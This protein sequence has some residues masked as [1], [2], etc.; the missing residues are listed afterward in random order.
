MNRFRNIFR[1]VA[2]VLRNHR[3]QRAPATG[4]T[5]DWLPP[6][7]GPGDWSTGLVADGSAGWYFERR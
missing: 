1:N 6:V 4:G 2:F 3:V 7:L 5:T